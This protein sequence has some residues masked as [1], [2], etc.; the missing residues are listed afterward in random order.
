MAPRTEER[1]TPL[2]LRRIELAARAVAREGGGHR[3]GELVL[4]PYMST[5][6]RR[7]SGGRG[8]LRRSANWT[9]SSGSSTTPSARCW[10][11]TPFFLHTSD[12]GAQ[13]PFGKWT[14]YEDGVRTPL[15]VSW[16]GRIAA[17]QRTDALVSWIDI[18]PTLVEAAEAPRRRRSTVVPFSR[19]RGQG[20]RSTATS[21]TRP[22][23][24]TGI[25]TSTRCAASSTR[26]VTSISATCIRSSVS[27]PCHEKQA[28]AATGIRGSTAPLS[29][30]TAR[31][32]VNAYQ[33]RP[34]AELYQTAQD[35]WSATTSRG[36]APRRAAR[37][38]SGALDGWM[39]ETK[40]PQTV[41]G[42]PVRIA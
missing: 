15:L 39:A 30:A 8:M 9:R 25:S 6:P 40:D 14:L 3:S 22:T 19:A 11:R 28:T 5:M 13:W 42:E 2:P 18:L 20:P 21:S 16:P 29:D 7:G 24:G 10:A 33:I 23:A 17:K 27:L 1:K 12:H 38:L 26:R 36:S 34:A 31:A 37:R 41:F 32:I 35:P 4:P